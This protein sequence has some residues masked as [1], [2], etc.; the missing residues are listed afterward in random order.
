MARASYRQATGDYARALE[1]WQ[2]ALAFAQQRQNRYGTA[3]VRLGMVWT[4]L[5]LREL[6]IAYAVLQDAEVAFELFDA[7]LKLARCSCAWAA[8][9]HAAEAPSA[10]VSACASAKT[11]A[12]ELQA[13]GLLLQHD[14]A[15]V[16][17]MLA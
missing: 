14:L 3:E 5:S 2:A 1:H 13:Q 12:A 6:S 7:R 8:Y 10:A 16:N 15:R 17:R 11:R 9:H 4:M